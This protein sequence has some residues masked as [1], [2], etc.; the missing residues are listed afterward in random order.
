[1]TNTHIDFSQVPDF[2][3]I[4]AG[5]YDAT[6]VS[7]QP[8]VA[9]SGSP[10]ID[11]R[12]KIEDGDQAGRQ[13]FDQMSFHPNALWRTKQSLQAID[14]RTYGKGFAGAVEAE[15]LIG[16]HATLIVVVEESNET[17]PATGEPFPSRS[18]VKSILPYGST[19]AS[20]MSAAG[21]K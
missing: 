18:K 17:D 7:A 4:P 15:D 1:M 8:G 19:A 14:G 11:L 5:R 9:K 10:K 3:A 13:V 21:K 2:E 16:Q 20:A 6:I 12:W